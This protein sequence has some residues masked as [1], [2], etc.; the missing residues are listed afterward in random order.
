MRFEKSGHRARH[1]KLD[2]TRINEL[3]LEGR[4]TSASLDEGKNETMTTVTGM[5]QNI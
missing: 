5:V 3:G 2:K 4:E 1:Y